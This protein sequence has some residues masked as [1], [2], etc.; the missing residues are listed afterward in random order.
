MKLL[1]FSRSALQW[2]I[3]GF[4]AITTVIIAAIAYATASWGSLPMVNTGSGLSANAWND[5]VAHVNQSVKQSSQVITV[6][7]SSVGIQGNIYNPSTLNNSQ[8]VV[9]WDS[10][11]GTSSASIALWGR[12]HP[13][14]A[15]DAHIISNGTGA[16]RFFNYKAAWVENMHI[17]DNGNVGMGTITPSERL[18]LWGGNI[19]MGYEIISN[20]CVSTTNCQAYC[21]AGK[22]PLWGACAFSVTG[23]NNSQVQADNYRCASSVVQSTLVTQ[24]VCANMK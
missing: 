4:S 2:V 22:I 14:W 19:K 17:N 10:L 20:S 16:I 12:S 5:L 23:V 3:F 7:G 8:I 1:S 11:G 15:G 24:V 21:T 9:S 13:S 6:N 18:D